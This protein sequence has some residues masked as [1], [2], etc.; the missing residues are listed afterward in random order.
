MHGAEI[1]SNLVRFLGARKVLWLPRG[2]EGDLD[3]NGH[4]DNMCCFLA[5][6]VVALHWADSTEDPLQHARSQAAW[7]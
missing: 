5:P 1:E 3:T 7:E 4:V 6:G 2:V